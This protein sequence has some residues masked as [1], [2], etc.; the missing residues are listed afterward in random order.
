MSMFGPSGDYEQTFQ[1][2]RRLIIS[3][4]YRVT[5]S[6]HDAEDVLRT[7]FIRLVRRWE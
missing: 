1:Q 2:Y 5:G 7:V 3:A 6:N 4:A